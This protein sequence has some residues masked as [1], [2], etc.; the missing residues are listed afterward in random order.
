M[1]ITKKELERFTNSKVSQPHGVLGMHSVK[2]K[3]KSGVVVR[4]FLSNAVSCEIVDI[5]QENS[6]RYP[7]KKLTDDGFFEGFIE[8]RFAS[9]VYIGPPAT[10]GIDCSSVAPMLLVLPFCEKSFVVDGVSG[11]QVRLDFFGIVI[12]ETRSEAA[13]ARIVALT[14]IVFECGPSHHAAFC[15]ESD[16]GTCS[17]IGVDGDADFIADSCS[18][19]SGVIEVGLEKITLAVDRL[20]YIGRL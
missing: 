7:M 16:V 5:E 3:G 20:G 19:I 17:K 2:K 12:D 1:L 9:D 6:P 8:G 10:I 11:D 13:G 15:R 4:A 14:E 18:D